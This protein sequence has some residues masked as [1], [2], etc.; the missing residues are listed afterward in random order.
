MRVA[1]LLWLLTAAA[2]AGWDYDVAYRDGILAVH[3]RIP[4]YRLWLDPDLW[5]Y[6]SNLTVTGDTASYR[7]DLRRC[8]QEQSH[9][10]IASL[11]GQAILTT[12]STFLLRPSEAEQGDYTLTIT[13]GIAATTKAPTQ[14]LYHAP[15]A[16]FGTYQ[17]RTF[18]LQ[19]G[20]VELIYQPVALPEEQLM[21]WVNLSVTGLAEYY[22]KLPMER[23][24][25]VILEH[26]GRG[27][28]G[29]A[30]G[31]S[32]LMLPSKTIDPQELRND[33]TLMHEL[34]HLG[35][36][37]VPSA[38]HW[39]EEGL[40]TYLEPLIRVRA[41][42]FPREKMWLDILENMPPSFPDESVL[43]RHDY[44]RY[45]WGG[46]LYWFL[47]DLRIRLQ[48]GKTLQTALQAIV[49]QGGNLTQDWTLEKAL[50]TGDH[51][52]G[53]P[54]LQETLRTQA[55]DLDYYWRQLGVNI[56]NAR[57]LLRAAPWAGIRDAITGTT[58]SPGPPLG[59]RP[60]PSLRPR[61]RTAPGPASS[62]PPRSS[63]RTRR[64][65]RSAT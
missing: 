65:V 33:W 35:F 17:T 1:L 23:V 44:N 6:V 5:P 25:L 8:A 16:V 19:G 3:A 40:A 11:H 34:T 39:V 26:E 46:A 48:T 37:C 61:T 29:L 51:A 50:Q 18:P 30:Q 13:G 64:A 54:I 41:G 45:Y 28:R 58:L 60:D 9:Y 27:V 53:K 21:Q 49:K 14:D 24:L 20:T 22:G 43:D 38:Y 7:F 47:A 63:S 42:D 52:L 4:T 56:E 31:N 12:P 32:V 2:W 36:P 59:P 62:A 15:A 55:V 10:K 57:L